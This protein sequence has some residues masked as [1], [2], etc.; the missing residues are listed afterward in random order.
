[1]TAD[2]YFDPNN[3]DIH[4][5]AEQLAEALGVPVGVHDHYLTLHVKIRDA[6]RLL[7]PEKD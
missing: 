1:M 6:R 4:E 7:N 3:P 5:L 2:D